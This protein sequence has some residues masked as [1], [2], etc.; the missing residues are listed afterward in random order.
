MTSGQGTWPDV[1]LLPLRRPYLEHYSHVVDD[2][3]P[4][5]DGDGIVEAGEE[6]YYRVT[7]KNT[8]QDR[9][10]GVTGALRAL[11]VSDRLPHPGVTVGDANASFGTLAPGQ[12][13]QGDRFAFTLGSTVDPLT[14]LLE[15]TLADALGPADL[16]FIDVTVPTEVD[17]VT[18]FGAPSSIRL[19]WNRCKSE[20][21]RGYDIERAT[22]PGGPFTRI[23][24]YT[25]DGTAA[26]E[27]RGLPAL[28]RYYYRIVAR[29]SSYNAS[30]P[31]LVISG[32]TNP[33]YSAGWPI[34]IGQQTSSSPIVA[35][36]DGGSHIEV[37]C[38]GDVQYAWHGD[39]TEVVDGDTDPRTNG[40]FSLYGRGSTSPGYAATPA[41]GNIDQTGWLE[42][43]NVTFSA[44]TLYV[45]NNQGQFMPGWPKSVL[46]DLNWGSALLA[47]LDQNGDLEIAVW[48]ANGGRLFA[49]HHT[50][51][52]LVDGDL[53][54]STDGVLARIFGTSFNYGSAAVAQLDADSPLEILV[55]VGR[56]TDQSG[57]IYAFNIDGT[58]VSGWPFFTGSPQTPSEVSSSIAVGDLDNDGDEEIV[59]SCERDGGRV[60]VLNRNGTVVG[61]WPQVAASYTTDA[62]LPSPVLA[63]IDGDGRLDIVYPDTNG[64]LHVWSRS[65]LVMPGFPVTY[66]MD[67][68]NQTTQST[69]SVGDIDGDARPEILFGDESGKVH[70]YN[71]DGT[72]APG[73]PI[74]LPGEVRSTPAL[75]DVD[76]DNL[77]EAVVTCYDGTV[78]MWDL[79]GPFNPTKLAW[80]FFRHDVQ[81]TGRVATAVQTGIEEPAPAVTPAV[82]AFHAA[83][84]NPFNPWTTLAFDV[85]G[86]ESGARPVT[87]EIVDVA[88][89]I[90]RRL[91]D[92]PVATGSHAIA[93]DGRGSNGAVAASGVYFARIRIGNFE[94]TQKLTLVR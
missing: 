18:A 69:P 33:P 86:A 78:Y 39:G 91:L 38:G 70:A 21:A 47:D 42:V 71:H 15:L 81:N 54:P 34:E 82:A 41:A 80:P 62:R 27:D 93:W 43:A 77:V 23:N 46:D 8:G 76:R 13:V 14:V 59:F 37:L 19:T 10:T 51:Q 20:D 35:D 66:F 55:P 89:R 67:P 58:F 1:T 12:Q 16:Q 45:W 63:D 87:L 24:T 17:T 30:R 83:R 60:Y 36:I 53:N 29:D 88:G 65:G 26:F 72:L 11:R 48:A 75:W 4:R 85:P 79:V 64:V 44:D 61:G 22:G 9:A 32:T 40:P 84:P 92:G 68:Q 28:T 7:L 25:V 52:E 6:I 90:V 31:S 73:F 2:A 74:Q 57:G 94:S 49:W 50:G 5:G 56:S 3:A